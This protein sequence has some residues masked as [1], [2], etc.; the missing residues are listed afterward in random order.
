MNLP[1]CLCSAG[2]HVHPDLRRAWATRGSAE[3]L[4]APQPSE[5]DSSPRVAIPHI[6]SFFCRKRIPFLCASRRFACFLYDIWAG[7]AFSKSNGNKNE[8]QVWFERESA[9][10]IADST[11]SFQNAAK[12]GLSCVEDCAT[13]RF[14]VKCCPQSGTGFW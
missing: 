14:L 13:K 4:V 1:P 9:K 7:A 8:I 2:T 10:K 12:S 11:K 5:T 3:Q 6:D